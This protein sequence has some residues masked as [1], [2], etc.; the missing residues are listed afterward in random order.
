MQRQFTRGSRVGIS[1]V[2]VAVVVIVIIVIAAVAGY[3]VLSSPKSSTTTSTTTTTTSSTT[4]VIPT[5]TTSSSTTT[6]TQ[7]STS[8]SVKFGLAVAT[9]IEYL[10][11]YVAL[12]GGF[13]TQQGVNVTLLPFQGGGPEIQGVAS[14]EISL[15]ETA[16]SGQI[17]A[18]SKG[19]PIQ[20]V[21]VALQP[22]DMVLIVANNSHYTDA[23]Q[24][25]GA[26]IGVTS[27]GSATDMMFHLLASHYNF[28]I[29]T[30]IHELAV[31]GLTAQLAAL[32]TNKTQAFF[33][34]YETGYQLQTLNDAKILLFM[35]TVI[36]NWEENIIFATSSL[37]SS[38]PTL[39][40]KVLQGISNAVA[41]MAANRTYAIQ[42]A[43]NYL[44]LNPQAA[45]LT[46]TETFSAGMFSTDGSFTSQALNGMSIVRS[47]MLQLNVSSSLVPVNQSYTTQ[48]VPVPPQSV[49]PTLP[50]TAGL[51]IAPNR[52]SK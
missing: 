37:I 4:S 16:Y 29:G 43:E 51:F 39:I 9:T 23:S 12:H 36:P 22:S 19:V 13:W 35:N 5:S 14:G 27:A 2:A 1:T 26:T 10:P 7:Q 44:S 42:Q 24:L 25:K 52:D 3:L 18:L 46:I 11:E 8:S 21:A 34:T 32:T 20:A 30:D 33:W 38:N 41:Y 40:H 31:G 47:L 50:A 48:F 45:N 28:T 49:S 17:Q 6:T 15:G